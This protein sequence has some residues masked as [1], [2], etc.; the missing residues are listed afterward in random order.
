MTKNT[1]IGL[2]LVLVLA[3]SGFY[4]YHLKTIFNSYQ[5]LQI[6]LIKCETQ[7]DRLEEE[8]T[9]EA[10]ISTQKE[11]ENLVLQEK[12]GKLESELSNCK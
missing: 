5:S 2:L 10:G 11:V 6:E 1:I 7:R 9:R 3:S 12:I 4:V 8:A